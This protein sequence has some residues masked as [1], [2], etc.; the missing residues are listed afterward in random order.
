MIA[1][2]RQP[3][4]KWRPA[5]PDDVP[6]LMIVANHIHPDLPEDAAIYAERIRLFPPG[7]HILAQQ[8]E[9][10]QTEPNAT[11]S[12]ETSSPAQA[13]CSGYLISHPIRAGQPPELNALLSGSS[14][15]PDADQYYIHDLALMPETRGQGH[16]A[17]IIAGLLGDAGPAREH[18]TACLI[19]VY[20][21]ASFWG[22]FGF[23]ETQ[24]NDLVFAKKLQGYGQD[25]KYM[26][27]QNPLWSP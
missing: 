4:A 27:R 17:E 20:G 11:S 23:V 22:R 26:V 1:H 24:V 12:A 18:R 7:C 6:M 25:A 2:T 16:A 3:S 10:Q 19:S 8:R 14:I 5:T 21:T 13:R 9:Q 15:S